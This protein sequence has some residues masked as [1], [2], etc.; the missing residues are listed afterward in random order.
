M[1][2]LTLIDTEGFKQRT[3]SNINTDFPKNHTTK[4]N[5][6]QNE[7]LKT[8]HPDIENKS[9]TRTADLIELFVYILLCYYYRLYAVI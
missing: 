5:P 2:S 4:P 6:C 9:S 3:T 1:I 8:T 7:V